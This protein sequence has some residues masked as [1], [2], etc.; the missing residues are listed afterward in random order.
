MQQAEIPQAVLE[1]VEADGSRRVVRVNQSPF[2]FGRGAEE[3]NHLQLADKRIS[4]R[5]GG[6]SYSDGNFLLEDRGQRQGVFVNGELVEGK[7]A[8]R[9]G[10]IITLGAADSFQLLFHTVDSHEAL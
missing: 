2:F 6:L 3:G 5:C 10:D 1:I 9:D 4:R 8:V 7:R